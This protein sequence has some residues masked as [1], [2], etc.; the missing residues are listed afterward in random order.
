MT[1]AS[2]LQ[3]LHL[4]VDEITAEIN[5]LTQDIESF[6]V[7]PDNKTLLKGP[8]KQIN[9]LK[10]I[11]TLLEFN[12]AIVFFSETLALLERLAKGEKNERQKYL[13]TVS[14]AI[15]KFLRYLEHISQKA[16]D[17]P[18]LLLPTINQLRVCYGNSEL[19][20]SY[21]FKKGFNKSRLGKVKTLMITEESASKSRH[22][23]Q[24]YQIGLIE[25]IRQTNLDGGLTM[26]K[27]S[28]HKLDKDCVLPKSPN[29]WWIAQASID[30]FV[31][32]KLRLTKS[33]LKLFSMLDRQIRQAENKPEFLL[34]DSKSEI[35]LL[36]NEL[37][38][39]VSISG[40]R[41]KLT[42]QVCQH[43][44]INNQI[45]NDELLN[46]ELRIL[47]GLTNQDYHSIVES[48]VD[49]VENLE[50]L[51]LQTK[52]LSYTTEEIESIKQKMIG[53]N[54]FLKILHIDDQVVR[55][56]VV[57]E[58]TNQVIEEKRKITPKEINILMIALKGLK[59]SVIDSGFEKYAGILSTQREILSSAQYK[60]CKNAHEKVK[61][62]ITDFSDFIESN[63]KVVL[64]KE[65]AKLLD[66]VTQ[67]FTDLN[68]TELATISNECVNYLNYYIIK[69]PRTISEEIIL[70]YADIIGSL[71]FYLETLQFTKKPNPRIIQFAKNSLAH[72]KRLKAQQS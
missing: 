55:I 4:L 57:V 66:V 49:E 44:S 31:E 34:V 14:T 67:S 45:V 12:G 53:L 20:E 51:L 3:S 70:V 32:K 47:H 65:S 1:Q 37:L 25:V 17:I 15:I 6:A 9:K 29:L 35:N 38:Y 24:M 10:G 7:D 48:L 54:N 11:F 39:L 18:Q 59:Q 71:E 21:F 22:Y 60:I 26:M 56:T 27:K 64:I 72:L 19:R 28:L 8:I 30:G 52:V 42:Q 36:T 41:T 62:F 58:L 13:E 43:F 46:E 2:S 69:N 68:E 23:R 50:T 40:C 5:Q 61:Q 33:R 63:R 16:F